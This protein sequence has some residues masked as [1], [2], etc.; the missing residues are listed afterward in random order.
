MWWE[1]VKCAR[2]GT[3]DHLC[4]VGSRGVPLTWR[5]TFSLFHS[6]NKSSTFEQSRPVTDVG[7]E[8][9]GS[10][11]MISTSALAI[12]INPQRKMKTPIRDLWYV[13]IVVFYKCKFMV[14]MY[15]LK[16]QNNRMRSVILPFMLPDNHSLLQCTI[17]QVG[18]M[19]VTCFQ[20]MTRDISVIK[21]TLIDW[22]IK[23]LLLFWRL[24]CIV[25]EFSCRPSRA[26]LRCS[27]VSAQRPIS[28]RAQ[29]WLVYRLLP[30]IA[31]V[32]GSFL[33]C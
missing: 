6:R 12:I 10:R 3:S 8:L 15:K 19:S 29:N 17:K 30:V 22:L 18:R 21:C 4:Q 23:V 1:C 11:I 14:T 7:P 33:F 24:N 27:D 13:T 2:P 31:T 5:H 25:L 26:K 32:S 9:R 20:A 28:W 16:H